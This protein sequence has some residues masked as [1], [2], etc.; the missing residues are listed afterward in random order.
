VTSTFG[1]TGPYAQLRGGPMAGWAAGGYLAITGKP[2]REPIIGPENLCDYIGGYNAA[3]A[4]EAAYHRRRRTGEGAT[5]DIATMEA[6][7]CVHQTTFSLLPLGVGRHRQGR[8]YEVYPLVTRPCR[9]G[10]VKL[11]IVTD[12]EYDRFLIA[13]GRPDL[14][15]DERFHTRQL[16]FV[17]RDAFDAEIA[18]FLEAHDG[19]AIVELLAEHGV[20][21]AKVATAD[22]VRNNPQLAHRGLWRPGPGPGSPIPRVQTFAAAARPRA[23]SALSAPRSPEL[24]LSGLVVADFT[25]FWA[26]PL[27]A[28]TLADLGARVIWVE[29]PGSRARW[30]F[31]EDPASADGADLYHLEMSRHKES[32]VLDLTR[33]EGLAAARTLIANADIVIENNRPGVMDRLGLGAEAVCAEFPHVVYVSLSGYGSFGPWANR[34]SYG[35]AIE[36]ASGIEGRTGYP[37]DEPLRLGHPLPDA[38]GGLGGALA[39]LRGLREREERGFGGWYDVSQL[40]AYIAMSGEDYVPGGPLPRIGNQSRWGAR[41]GVFPCIGEDNWIAIRLDG[42]ADAQAFRAALGV[43]FADQA[44]LAALTSASE[45]RALADRLQAAGLE[46]FPVLNCD[47]LPDD[48]HLRARGFFVEV[49][50]GG[51]RIARFPG[52]PLRPLAQARGP[53]PNF[54]DQT[55]ALLREIAQVAGRVEGTDAALPGR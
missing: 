51:G 28:R 29:R 43:D 26:G 53:S 30:N 1:T 21:A 22:D 13:I 48:P 36:A 42:E 17:N 32:L 7:Q 11:S 27:A 54:G 15:T 20:T 39:A 35:P 40:E 8:Y 45:K 23:T 52:S 55:A 3:I 12:E 10:Y 38:T 25:V 31:D 4:A 47:E 5:I 44:A 41:Q 24:P 49:G 46:A 2:D 14:S 16:C 37:G 33:P 6:M 18:P 34:R 19:E 50:F 9:D